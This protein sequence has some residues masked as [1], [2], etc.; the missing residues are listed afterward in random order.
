M[1]SRAQ[2]IEAQ[3]RTMKSALEDRIGVKVEAEAKIATFMAEYVGY[4]L[5]RLEV[6]EDGKTAYER[7]RGKTAKL[8][9][10]EFGEKLMWKVRPKDKMEKLNPRWEYGIFIGVRRRSGEL[11]IATEDGLKKVRSVRRIPSEQRWSKGCL[12]WATFFSL[13][14]VRR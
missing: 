5:N 11:W 7:I 10:I 13:E 12:E 8:L 1:A 2:G 3:I 9:G 14:Q 6:G 4:L